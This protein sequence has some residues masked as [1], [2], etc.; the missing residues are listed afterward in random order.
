[1][2]SRE[3]DSEEGDGA[4]LLLV[5]CVRGRWL[6]PGWRFGIFGGKKPRAPGSGRN[7]NPFGSF[8]RTSHGTACTRT[9][10]F[11]AKKG[12]M[13]ADFKK[14]TCSCLGCCDEDPSCY[15]SFL[16]KFMYFSQDA[17][18]LSMQEILE[19]KPIDSSTCSCVVLSTLFK[20]LS[21]SFSNFCFLI[22]SSLFIIFTILIS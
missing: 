18:E 21:R 4:I 11:K 17:K 20:H 13:E 22:S 5:V 2:A 7:K 10:I 3:N 1:M 15:F 14:K 9:R 6:V 16:S 8:R 19:I 12:K